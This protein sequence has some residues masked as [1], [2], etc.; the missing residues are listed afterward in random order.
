L[1]NATSGAGGP[2]SASLSTIFLVFLRIG[3]V[4]FG[5]GLFGWIHRE[6]V[7]KRGWLT[8]DEFFSGL[9][10][11]Q[12][13]PGTNVSNM[14]VI[15]GQRLRDQRRGRRSPRPRQRA[16]RLHHRALCRLRRHR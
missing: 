9:A 2:A 5:G 16:V 3:L 1:Q 11:A 13:L 14:T 10:L 12:V 6:V 4:S 15:I 7:A 8:D